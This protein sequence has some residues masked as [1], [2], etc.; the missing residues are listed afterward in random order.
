MDMQFDEM[1]YFYEWVNER[2]EE[3]NKALSKKKR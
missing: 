2:W 3:E 1:L